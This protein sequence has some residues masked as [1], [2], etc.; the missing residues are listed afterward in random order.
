MGS[1]NSDQEVL[2]S[3]CEMNARKYLEEHQLLQLLNN[4]TS[5]MIYAKPG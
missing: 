2:K 3:Q 4:M 1:S 5:M